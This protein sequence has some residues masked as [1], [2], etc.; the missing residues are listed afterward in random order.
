MATTVHERTP[1]AADE[2][3]LEGAAHIPTEDPT[4]SG[5]PNSHMLKQRV[6][7]ALPAYNE[8]ASL[9]PLLDGIRAAMSAADIPY[10]I[11]VVDD[12][13]KDDTALIASQASFSM[14]V[15]LVEHG[16]NQGLAAALRTCFNAAV[17]EAHPGDV[18]VTM[19]ADNTHPPALIQRMLQL[20]REGH[21]VVIASRYRP[22][23]RVVGVPW[24]RNAMSY[25]ARALFQVMFPIRGVRDY[26]CGF[27]AYRVDV[28][29][30]ALADFGDSFVSEKG[31][32]C[33]ADVLLKLRRYPLVVGEAP[34]ILRY[35]LKGG[36][37]KMRVARTVWQTLKLM[38]RRRFQ[39]A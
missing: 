2:P 17:E 3:R 10:L 16:A 30:R 36:V 37:S 20:V 12:G 23:S 21:D 8:G 26:T 38:V 29:E 35:D 28:L 34:M 32:S 5:G 13:S 19:D 15:K 14:P 6:I 7:V 33:M 9:G 39:G 4:R 18:I 27:R 25:G 24:H 31:F 11:V 1:R 22:G